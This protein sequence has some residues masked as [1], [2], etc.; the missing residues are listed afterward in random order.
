MMRDSGRV[1]GYSEVGRKRASGR[2]MDDLLQ[3]DFWPVEGF[4]IRLKTVFLKTDY[5]WVARYFFPTEENATFN[6][7]LRLRQ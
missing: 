4:N 7:Q 6:L 5:F 2:S 3:A 1:V